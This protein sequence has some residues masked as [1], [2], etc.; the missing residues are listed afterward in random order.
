MILQ[1][2]I[3]ALEQKVPKGTVI[4]NEQNPYEFQLKNGYILGHCAKAP[5]TRD[6]QGKIIDTD[7]IE[8]NIKAIMHYIH[9]ELNDIANIPDHE[10]D[11]I[12]ITYREVNGNLFISTWLYWKE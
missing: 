4:V 2:F 1:E 6:D 10:F 11:H 12:Q 9:E 3:R 5:I 7:T 8:N